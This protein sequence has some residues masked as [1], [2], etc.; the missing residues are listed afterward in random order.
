MEGKRKGVSNC[1]VESKEGEKGP[2]QRVGRRKARMRRYERRLSTTECT[3]LA[4]E[5]EG[6]GEGGGRSQESDDRRGRRRL[7]LGVGNPLAREGGGGFRGF[8]RGEGSGTRPR[9]T[10]T[11]AGGEG[12][13]QRALGSCVECFWLDAGWGP[14]DIQ[15]LLIRSMVTAGI[16]AASNSWGKCGPGVDRMPSCLVS[17]RVAG[18]QFRRLV[19]FA[20][21]SAGRSDT[22]WVPRGGCGV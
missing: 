1:T 21:R 11:G 15:V 7:I 14:F 9:R 2:D 16:R 8:R 4:R 10:G 12:L 20:L 22:V 19:V 13:C 3:A 6:K 17:S 18:A 5:K